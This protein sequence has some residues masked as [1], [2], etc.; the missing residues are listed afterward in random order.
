MT[1]QVSSDDDLAHQTRRL[2]DSLRKDAER[3]GWTFHAPPPKAA[4]PDFAEDYEPDAMMITPEGGVMI[5]ITTRSSLA[6]N[7][8]LAEIAQRVSEQPGWSF[9]VFYA[10]T[11]DPPDPSTPPS[12]VEE[13]A[14]SITE[15]RAL[16][17]TG[18][19]RAALVMG[20][21]TLE[22][23]ARLVVDRHGI[24]PAKPLSPIQAVQVLVQEG[25]LDDDDAR[26]LR[27]LARVRNE[28]VHGGLGVAISPTDLAGLIEDL[29]D[30]AGVLRQAA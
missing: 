14:S 17:E 24:G 16:D 3:R 28:I 10:N 18:H 8:R 29:E 26:R 2:L 7:A 21:A 5:A 11:S 27:S 15:V 19:G 25:Y 23:I 22:A 12:T 20:W 9:R 6:R 30:M 1:V 4:V 13:I